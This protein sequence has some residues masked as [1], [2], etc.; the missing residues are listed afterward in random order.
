MTGSGVAGRFDLESR[1][2]GAAEAEGAEALRA[3]LRLLTCA[4]LIEST[5]RRRLRE[6]FGVT[7]PRFDLMAQLERRPEGI[8]L[9]EVAQRM[10]VS[11]GNVTGLVE[12]LSAEGLVERLESPND[13]RSTLVRLTPS[14]ADAFAK[15]AAAHRGWVLGLFA[16]VAPEDRQRLHALLGQLKASARAAGSEEAADAA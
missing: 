13:R 3:W 16:D 14:G 8:S 4:N 6:R 5:L 7:L 9:G 12:R 1:A 11:N 10:M 2:T 15:M